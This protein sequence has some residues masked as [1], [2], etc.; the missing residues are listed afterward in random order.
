MF[1]V[2]VGAKGKCLVKQGK[3]LFFKNFQL[4]FEN[5]FDLFSLISNVFVNFIRLKL[6][7]ISNKSKNLGNK[8]WGFQYIKTK[9][10]TLV[11]HT[12]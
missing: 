6:K 3:K 12:L 11:E 9:Y 4:A 7:E 2:V 5:P 8:Y 1:R 10:R